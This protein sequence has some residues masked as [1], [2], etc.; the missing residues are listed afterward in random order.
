MTGSDIDLDALEARL[1]D[2]RQRLDGH[3]RTLES[4]REGLGSDGGLPTGA[5]GAGGLL[6]ALGLT[7]GAASAEPRGQVGADERPVERVYLAA[8]NGPVTGGQRVTS[9]VG[10]GLAVEDGR[11]ALADGD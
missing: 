10:D 9:L 11:L 3:E 1:D 8:L 2:H 5:V 7:A 4:V 6:A